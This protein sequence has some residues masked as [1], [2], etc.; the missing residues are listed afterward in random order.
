VYSLNTDSYRD[1]DL[2]TTVGINNACNQ[3]RSKEI[4]F[5]ISVY[6]DSSISVQELVKY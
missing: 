5:H 1:R 6:N 4:V 2:G 3:G